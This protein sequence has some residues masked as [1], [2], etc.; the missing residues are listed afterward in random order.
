M[1][2]EAEFEAKCYYVG[3]PS[4]PIKIYQTGATW[5]RP[6]GPEAYHVRKEMRLV[7][8][9]PIAAAW[10]ELSPQVCDYLDYIN[11]KWT[12]I[13]VVRFADVEKDPGPPVIWIGVMPASLSLEDAEAAAIGIEGLFAKFALT[14]VLGVGVEI[15]FRESVFTRRSRRPQLLKYYPGRWYASPH[16]TADVRG[17]LTPTLGLQIAARDTPDAEGTGAL[18]I[19]DGTKVFVLTARHVVLPPNAAGPNRDELYDRRDED[20]TTTEPRRDVLILGSKAF[21]KVLKS[22]EDKVRGHTFMVNHYTD[23]LESE[24]ENRAELEKRLQESKEPID[25]LNELHA[26]VTNN[27]SAESQRILGHIVYSPPI[28]V[29]T[30]TNTFTEDWALIELDNEKIDWKTFRGNVID[31]GMYF[32]TIYL[33]KAVSS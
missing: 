7:F 14:G 18:Y 3:L 25:P 20:A 22:I 17:P 24:L 30:G 26:D 19:R 8:D 4:N 11:I 6:T 9:H 1:I 15:A 28:S 5:H 29:S 32:D 12:S 21:Q 2:S 27:W 31:L 23:R 33:T 13:D 10:D 16:A